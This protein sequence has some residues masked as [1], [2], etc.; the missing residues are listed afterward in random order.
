MASSGSGWYIFTRIS[1]ECWS[2]SRVFLGP[3]L[4]LLYIK[5]NPDDV[6]CAIAI[7][8]DATLYSKSDQP[9]DLWQQVELA[10][11]PE[12][13]PQDTVYQSRKWLVD[14]NSRKTQLVLFD[15]FNNTG[16]IDV[17]MDW[18]NLE[19][20]SS[21]KMLKLTF[22]FKFHWGSNIIFIAKT[23]IRKIGALICSMKFFSRR[24]LSLSLKIYHTAMHG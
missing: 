1:S 7:Y 17:K 6:I 5:D 4:F 9:S 13:G 15:W 23:S 11:E 24:L 14:F 19:E 16:A 10:S 3:T 12:C 21:F 2:F 22:S 8:A 20:K 18:S